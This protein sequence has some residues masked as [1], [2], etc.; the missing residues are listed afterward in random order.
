MLYTVHYNNLFL[1]LDVENQN[2]APIVEATDEWP[3]IQ[4]VRGN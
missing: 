3:S 1:N 2:A 4:E